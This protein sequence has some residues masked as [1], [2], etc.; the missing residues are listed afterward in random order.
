M[1][2]YHTITNLGKVNNKKYIDSFL[3]SPTRNPPRKYG[4]QQKHDFNWVLKSI[5]LSTECS[6]NTLICTKTHSLHKKTLESNRLLQDCVLHHGKKPH[7]DM[8]KNIKHK[9]YHPHYLL[10]SQQAKTKE[11]NKKKEV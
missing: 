2:V 9:A 1:K 4:K 5:T 7:T 8:Q 11:E 6:L 3:P 10:W